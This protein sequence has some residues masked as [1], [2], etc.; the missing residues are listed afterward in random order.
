[1][2]LAKLKDSKASFEGVKGQLGDLE[3]QTGKLKKRVNEAKDQ[4]CEKVDRMVACLDETLLK[5]KALGLTLKD[6]ELENGV[7]PSVR[8]KLHGAIDA[9]DAERIDKMIAENETNEVLTTTL[10]ALRM[11]SRHKDRFAVFDLRGVEVDLT[12]GLPP[13]VS[14]RFV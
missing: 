11:A 6:F 3:A 1:M 4:A 14:V 8:A 10:K 9:V 7:I 13:S 2:N 12:L 5:I